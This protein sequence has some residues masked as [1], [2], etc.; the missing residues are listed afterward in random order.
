MASALDRPAYQTLAKAAKRYGIPRPLMTSM[1]AQR[2]IPTVVVPGH[3]PIV[4]PEDVEAAIEAMR[5][6]AANPRDQ[7]TN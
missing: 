5:V 2:L 6:P 4:R 1:V 3:L 7:P